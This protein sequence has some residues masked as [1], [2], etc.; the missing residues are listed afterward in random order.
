MI[1]AIVFDLDDTLLDTSAC[2]VPAANRD[3]AR[4]LVDAGLH[5]ASEVVLRRRWQ[6]LRRMP[7]EDVDEWVCRQFGELRPAV[8]AAGRRAF[9][10]RGS[11]MMRG[12]LRL[13]PGARA[14]LD[15]LARV[16][17][18]FLVTWGDVAT[19]NTKI[20][21]LRLGTWFSDIVVVD[22]RL[23]DDKV[24][25]IE[26]LLHRH[27]LDPRDI[28]VVGDGWAQEIA[29]GAGLRTRTCW[30]SRGRPTPRWPPTRVEAV[31]RSVR[32]LEHVIRRMYGSPLDTSAATSIIP[33]ASRE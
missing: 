9:F 5:Q 8:A 22:R 25:A 16:H 17:A 6:A 24:R 4:A 31:V 26:G 14:T 27:R 1:R 23:R 30:V 33:L 13:V 20:R 2:L 32:D 11:R 18:L 21:L 28:V 12:P 15:R 29:A 10:E 7:V 3:A 19:Q